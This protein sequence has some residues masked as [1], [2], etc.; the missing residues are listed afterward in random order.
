[1]RSRL[2]SATRQTMSFKTSSRS[3][4]RRS[5]RSSSQAAPMDM[6]LTMDA[7]RRSSLLERDS[8]YPPN[9]SSSEI[10]DRS[11]VYPG[12]S[13]MGTRTQLTSSSVPTTHHKTS[14]SPS[15]FGSTPYSTVLPLPTTLSIAPLPTSTI[16]MPPPK[17]SV[18]VDKTTDCAISVMSL[19]LSKLRCIS[20]RTTSRRAAK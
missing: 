13:I 5:T 1:M 15:L 9:L 8:S 3:T 4:P 14:P 10:T 6:S 20:L 16:G 2:R 17:S 19:P 12:R 11:C 7:F 18:T